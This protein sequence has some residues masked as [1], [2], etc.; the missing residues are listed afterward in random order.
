MVV[1]KRRVVI[2]HVERQGGLVS[3]QMHAFRG[4]RGSRMGKV[5]VRPVGAT[6][7]PG[8]LTSPTLAVMFLVVERRRDNLGSRIVNTS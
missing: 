3:I 6:L 5:R 8:L 2:T 4:G 7:I 1:S